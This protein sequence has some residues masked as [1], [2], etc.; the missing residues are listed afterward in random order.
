M[1]L[2]SLPSGAGWHFVSIDEITA[3]K[4]TGPKKTTVIITGGVALECSEDTHVIHKRIEDFVK[5][6]GQKP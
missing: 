6:V 2:V 5:F 1:R 3:V 4:Y